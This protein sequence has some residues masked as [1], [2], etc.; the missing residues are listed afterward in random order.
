MPETLNSAPMTDTDKIEKKVFLNAPRS[1]VW[2]AI[3]DSQQFG[4]WF[5]V[6]FDEPFKEGATIFGRITNPGYEN[7]KLEMVVE[8]IQ[9]ESYFSYRWHPYGVDKTRDYSAEPMTLIEFALE[10]ANGGTNLTIVESG[11]DGIPLDRR[12]EAFRMNNNG[13]SG[14]LKNIERYVTGT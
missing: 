4:E 2:R 6:K 10:E 7:V 1:K 3:A 12:A 11:F 8:K 14:Q 5:R 9:P 13:W